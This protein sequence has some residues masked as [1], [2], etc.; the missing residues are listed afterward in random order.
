MKVPI[1]STFSTRIKA[2]LAAAKSPKKKA[3]LKK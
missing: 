3:V 2:K 1:T